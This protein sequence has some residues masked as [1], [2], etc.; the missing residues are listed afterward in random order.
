MLAG[1]GDAIDEPDFQLVRYQSADVT[2]ANRGR[3]VDRTLDQL[4]D[5][6]R[7]LPDAERYQVVRQFEARML[8]QAYIVPLLWW[9][10]MVALSPKVKG[11][12][13]APSHLINQDLEQ[14]WLAR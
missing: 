5:R 13:M 8:E 10:R 1:E 2:P 6:Q 9:H 4:Y 14:V 11:W 3:Y 7:L 12:Y